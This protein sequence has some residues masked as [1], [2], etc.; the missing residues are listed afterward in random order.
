VTKQKETRSTPEVEM[1]G[2]HVHASAPMNTNIPKLF[3]SA[4]R[5]IQYEGI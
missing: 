5:Q 1:T 4:K 3:G 2:H